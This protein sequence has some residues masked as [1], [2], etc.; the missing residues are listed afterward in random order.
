MP[1]IRG[2]ALSL[3]VVAALCTFSPLTAGQVAEPDPAAQIQMANDFFESARYQE[4]L[5]AYN[6]AIQSSD[7]ALVTRARKGK[8]RTALRVAE[9]DLARAEAETLNESAGA[10]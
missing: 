2:F 8:V 6:L 1:V 7:P 10:D 4:A 3:A 5:D 9:F